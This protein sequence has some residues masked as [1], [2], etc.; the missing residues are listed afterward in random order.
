MRICQTAHSLFS[1]HTHETQDEEHVVSLHDYVPIIGS[2]KS[3]YEAVAVLCLGDTKR[4]A[5][6]GINVDEVTLSEFLVIQ[7]A[8]EENTRTIL[9]TILEDGKKG[10]SKE[11]RDTI[12]L[13]D[14]QKM[15]FGKSFKAAFVVDNS[16]HSS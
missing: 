15:T 16:V 13:V 6:K 5:E 10:R 8:D 11:V 1:W 3:T 4:A 14:A 12:S 2:V 7:G 9:Q